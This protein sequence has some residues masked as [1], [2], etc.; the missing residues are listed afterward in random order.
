MIGYP[1]VVTIKIGCLEII[2]Y[3]GFQWPIF[4]S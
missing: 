2:V 4:H 3:K 1:I